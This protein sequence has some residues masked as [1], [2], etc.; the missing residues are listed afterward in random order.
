[1]Q[2]QNQKLHS[3]ADTQSD[4]TSVRGR[5]HVDGRPAVG[6]LWKL[7]GAR[8][9]WCCLAAA[10]APAT[11]APADLLSLRTAASGVVPCP[12]QATALQMHAL[13]S[14]PALHNS[15]EDHGLAGYAR[16]IF[17]VAAATCT[18]PA[19]A[20]RCDGHRVAQQPGRR[21]PRFLC[22]HRRRVRLPPQRLHLQWQH[23][24]PSAGC[25]EQAAV[26]VW[27]ARTQL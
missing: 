15:R 7:E 23:C 9:R 3:H 24:L 11:Y 26:Q 16:V 12:D 13:S 5:T 6:G 27:P 4:E 14:Q 10:A 1:M 22:F 18:F 25:V 19:A 17:F 8:R 20:R 2:S 21:V